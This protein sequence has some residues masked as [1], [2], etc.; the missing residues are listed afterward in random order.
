[1]NVS[2]IADVSFGE[3]VARESKR[4]SARDTKRDV[5]REFDSTERR[6]YETETRYWFLDTV[7]IRTVRHPGGV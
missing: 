1:M 2:T 3:Q 7:E 6:G 5:D 4:G